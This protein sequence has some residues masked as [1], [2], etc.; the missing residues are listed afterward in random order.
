MDFRKLTFWL[1]IDFKARSFRCIALAVW[2]SGGFGFDTV[3]GAE[4]PSY[5]REIRPIL[6]EHCFACHGQDDKA[7]K[8]DLRLDL[9]NIA[10][11]GGK[12]GRPAVQPGNAAGS[13]LMARI[14]SHDPDVR[15]PP[16]DAKKPVTDA[17]IEILRRWVASGAEYQPHWSFIEP[18]RPKLPTLKTPMSSPDL[19]SPIDAFV[20]ARLELENIKPAPAADRPAL[21]RRL[22]LDLTGLPPSPQELES[23]LNDST[24]DA[25]SKQVD[26]L[27]A[28]PHFGERWAQW[29]L[30]AARYSD[31]DGY[32]K[33]LPR[34]QWPW[35]DWVIQALNR[36][37]PYDRFIVEQIAG[38]LLPNATQDQ[39][40]ATGFLRNSMVNEEGAIIAEQFRTEG[41]IDRMD[42]LGKAVLGLTMQCAQCHSHKFDPLTQEEYYR[43]FA[44]INNDFESIGHV[45]SP[46]QL[47]S[48]ERI[49]RGIADEET[50]LKRMH[51]DWQR[52]L[53]DW[54]V[55]QRAPVANWEPLD[56]TEQFLEGGLAHPEELPDHSIITLGFR[57][58]GGDLRVLGRTSRTNLTGLRLEAMTHGDLAFGGPG[59]SPPG[60]FAVSE[61][62][63]EAR[64]AGSTNA[65]VRV[66][67]TNATADFAEP[68]HTFAGPKQMA[69]DDKRHLGPVGYLIDGKEDTAWSAD[70]GRGRRNTDY[71]AVAQIASTNAPFPGAG[72]DLR[73]T[74]Q[75]R[76]AGP[77]Q[78]NFLGRFRISF[79][80]E[81]TPVAD[82]L[83]RPVR[84]ALAKPAEN[85]T[86]TE[87]SVIFSTWRSMSFGTQEGEARI[88]ALWR[89][90]PEGDTVL[91]LAQ[92]PPEL[93]RETS[94]LERGSWQKPGRKVTA[95]TPAFLHPLPA[96][97]DASRLTLGRWFVDRRSPT[98]AR[99]IVNRVWQAY[100]GLGLVETP[101][102]FGVR[103]PLPT[104]PELL[105]W[106]AVEFM[107]PGTLPALNE[108]PWSLKHLHRL[109]VNSATYRQAAMVDA[110]LLARDPLN[111]LLARG[112]RFRAD[113]EMIRD[114]ALSA[115]GLLQERVGGAS[116]YPPVPES[117]FALNYTKIAWPTA[118]GSERYRRSLYQFRRRSMPDPVLGGFDAP[119]GDSACVRRV[120]SNTPL[121]ALTGLNETVFVEASRALALR[122]L[123]EAKPTESDRIDY[124]FRLC[125]G[126]LPKPAE[127]ILIRDLLKSR[128]QRVA[129]GWVPAREIAFTDP[130]SVEQLPTG[131]NPTQAAAW[132]IVSR[133]LLNLDETLTK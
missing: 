24:P 63:L 80:D 92:R 14:T 124:A 83:P 38:D 37:L 50:A 36:D 7:R 133:V 32:E 16:P 12:S 48:I 126:R 39:R 43:I 100:F 110:G 53:S 41:L 9:R 71:E 66:G 84:A 91:N 56:A 29:W 119:N 11:V 102:D 85:R 118:T 54:E 77:G 87:Q 121:A 27:L 6:A 68:D 20:R 35:R 19:G 122:T 23:F 75:F 111:R 28:S 40:T 116:F 47:K 109:I 117:M 4:A 57:P 42:C 79:T 108:Q 58:S 107:E 74:L 86:P 25:Y 30:D 130:V 127:V 96:G 76:H 3:E 1:R 51:P 72:L 115:A 34:Q 81:P 61:L 89:D 64:P 101:E 88:E 103:A 73:V 59:R 90:Y 33:D 67:L 49:H 31:S 2:L 22:S 69:S 112:P 104:H 95:G 99:V 15:M 93:A 8:G 120:R 18:I 125:T 97:A 62:V 70:R 46:E 5:T 82:P 65:W 45:Y 128:Q 60:T 98:T 114:V 44:Y 94:L 26:R 13:E 105:D 52:R 123:R 10:L 78:D 129:D 21:L 131:T 113:A 55:Q 17:E 132:A 106:L